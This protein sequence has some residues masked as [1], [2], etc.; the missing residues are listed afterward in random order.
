MLQDTLL[1]QGL[2]VKADTHVVPPRM[3]ACKIRTQLYTYICVYELMNIRNCLHLY[4]NKDAMRIQPVLRRR[5]IC[6]KLQ[7]I[8]NT[9]N[10]D[11]KIGRVRIRKQPKK[12][13]RKRD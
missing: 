1:K 5:S 7:Y 6:E 11:R 13:A 12:Q 10:T 4:L 8:K 2:R 3:N 9:H